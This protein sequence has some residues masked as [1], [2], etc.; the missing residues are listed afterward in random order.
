MHI[1]FRFT[2]VYLYKLYFSLFF[3]QCS[4][5]YLCFLNYLLKT[6]VI[7]ITF[8]FLF[9]HLTLYY[10]VFYGDMVIILHSHTS[11]SAVICKLDVMPKDIHLFKR[12]YLLLLYSVHLNYLC[13]Q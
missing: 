3:P 7:H 6:E 9:N 2:P 12:E 1:D 4:E 10:A 8:M 13:F 11:Y 5:W